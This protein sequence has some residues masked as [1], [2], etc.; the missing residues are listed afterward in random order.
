MSGEPLGSEPLPITGS[1]V[2]PK[3]VAVVMVVL[4]LPCLP[5]RVGVRGGARVRVRDCRALLPG[6]GSSI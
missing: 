4:R 3:D 6:L 2:S 1:V 5:G